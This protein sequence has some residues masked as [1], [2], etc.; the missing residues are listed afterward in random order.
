MNIEELRTYLNI[1]ASLTTL[2]A[3]LGIGFKPVRNRVSKWLA[4]LFT[5]DIK[6]EMVAGFGAVRIELGKLSTQA[7]K[8]RTLSTRRHNSNT[9][10]LKKIGTGLKVANDRLDEH[11]SDIKAHRERT[12]TP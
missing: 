11:E 2:A 3:F 10:E 1:A 9:K 7:K 8:D 5:A 4:E 12:E 6:A